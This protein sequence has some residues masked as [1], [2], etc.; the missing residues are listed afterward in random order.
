[1]ATTVRHHLEL[2]CGP[3]VVSAPASAYQSAL[4]DVHTRTPLSHASRVTIEHSFQRASRLTGLPR[5]ASPD[6]V[7]VWGVAEQSV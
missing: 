4:A 1:M 2:I 5:K 3:L 7:R 6:E